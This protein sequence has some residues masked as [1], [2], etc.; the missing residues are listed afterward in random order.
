MNFTL[1]KQIDEALERKIIAYFLQSKPYSFCHLPSRFLSVMKIK[2]YVQFL[3]DNCSVY[4]GR[5][6]FI[7]LT[8]K[9]E[10]AI[11]E[12]LFGSAFTIVNS[13]KQFRIQ[14]KQKNPEVNVFF[15]EIQ[16][17]YKRDKLIKMIKQRDENAEIKLDNQ[18]ICVLWNT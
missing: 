17:I 6:F 14:F 18:K 1:I 10:T 3:L 7:A 4:V 11:V 9:K 8:I 2:E 5:D 12:F 15:S 16:R 13:F